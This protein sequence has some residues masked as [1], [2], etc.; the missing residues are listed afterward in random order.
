MIAAS[1]AIAESIP[2]DKLSP[3]NIIPLAFD[4]SVHKK[5]AEKVAEA[6]RASGVVRK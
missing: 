2:E 5:V 1:K 6:A 4:E 3:E